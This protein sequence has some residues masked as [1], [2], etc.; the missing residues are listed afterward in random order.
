MIWT[1]E[2]VPE[3]RFSP[4]MLLRYMLALSAVTYHLTHAQYAYDYDGGDPCAESPA[5]PDLECQRYTS[6][7][8]CADYVTNCYCDD[9]CHYYNDCCPDVEPLSSPVAA[10][11]EENV[12]CQQVLIGGNFGWVSL[13]TSCP[14]GAGT[15]SQQ[16]CM[17]GGKWTCDR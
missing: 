13:I 9:I 3:V 6:C 7:T 1:T 5:D 4:I 15:D 14:E 8:Q 10:V 16:N 2:G 12:E 17:N 11:P